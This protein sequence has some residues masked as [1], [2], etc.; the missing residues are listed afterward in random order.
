MIFFKGSFKKR[1]RILASLLA[2]CLSISMVPTAS[3]AQGSDIQGHWAQKTMEKWVSQKLMGGYGEGY[4]KPDQEITRIEFMA[5]LNKSLGLTVGT[6]VSFSD[7]NQGTWKT[8]TAGIA[9]SA[10]YVSGY[11]DGTLK[12]DAP[13]TR[14]EAASMIAKATG[15]SQ[16]DN[17]AAVSIKDMD[18]LSAWS[19]DYVVA[20]FQTKIMGGYGNGHFKPAAKITRAESVAALD[21]VLS[22]YVALD[23]PGVYTAI[24]GNQLVKKHLI[25]KT[26]GVT[27]KGLE[28]QGQIIALGNQNTLTLNG[29]FGDIFVVG[30]GAS[31]AIKDK[32]HL[33]KLTIS[34]A[35]TGVNVD[36]DEA[37]VI[38]KV[39]MRG[40]TDLRGT[41]TVREA[42]AFANGIT[43]QKAPLK[44]T[45]DAKVALKPTATILVVDNKLPLGPVLPM[46]AV[47]P[48]GATLPP[49]GGGS[50]G[51][52]T[53]PP[54]GGGSSGGGG[55]P[56]TPTVPVPIKT[57][58]PV[59]NCSEV[60]IADGTDTFKVAVGIKE[61]YSN[62]TTTFH[63]P[64]GM[65]AKNSD[66][67]RIGSGAAYRTIGASPQVTLNNSGNTVTVKNIETSGGL[68]HYLELVLQDVETQGV[69]A[70]TMSV[71][72]DK[73]GDQ[74]TFT[75]SEPLD[76]RFAFV[77][78]Q[79]VTFK[80]TLPT[81]LKPLSEFK[82][83]M[84]LSSSTPSGYHHRTITT[85]IKNCGPEDAFSIALPENSVINAYYRISEDS[86]LKLLTDNT[87]VIRID[88]AT[89][90]SK[91]QEIQLESGQY[92]EGTLILPSDLDRNL[93]HGIYMIAS[94][95]QNREIRYYLNKDFLRNEI[96]FKFIARKGQNRLRYELIMK[97]SAD[98]A[99]QQWFTT[100]YYGLTG[101]TPLSNG[102]LIDINNDDISNLKFNV[103]KKSDVNVLKGQLTCFSE[104][105]S[106]LSRDIRLAFASDY[107]AVNS[108]IQF[109]LPEGIK[110]ANT[111]LISLG[112][113]SLR[114]T[115]AELGEN[116]SISNNG[117]TLQFK[118]YSARTNANVYLTLKDRI[119]PEG[120]YQFNATVDLDGPGS[121]Y[122][123]SHPILSNS[124]VSS[125]HI[126]IAGTIKTIDGKPNMYE[127]KFFLITYEWTESA[128]KNNRKVIDITDLTIPIGVKEV[129]FKI[130]LPR[131]KYGIALS[132]INTGVEYLLSANGELVK[133]HNQAIPFDLVKNNIENVST[134]LLPNLFVQVT[135]Q[136]LL[137][138]LY[139][140]STNSAQSETILNYENTKEFT[141]GTLVFEL[142]EAIAFQTG[143]TISTVSGSNTQSIFDSNA[144][145]DYDAVTH[146]LTIKNLD[147]GAGSTLR[148]KM[149]RL[150]KLL[151]GAY[152]IKVQG[153]NDGE[154]DCFSPSQWLSTTIE[155]N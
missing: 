46:P 67:I 65:S 120:T 26:D 108:E 80:P 63:L 34:E 61:T 18:Q 123:M 2:L 110:F 42:E 129:T 88:N 27:L 57:Q 143:D 113:G 140:K 4:Y 134:V 152:T 20:V 56:T 89:S 23:K 45:L 124:V 76:L 5:L 103:I 48:G 38:E 10:G 119:V 22:N 82:L 98:P 99:A 85:T 41:G 148:L 12:P 31:I 83:Y 117:K 78:G 40:A 32:T 145:C 30:S 16:L 52:S 105:S 122:V 107:E 106:T 71:T 73:D 92:I 114:R 60:L 19:Q 111:D 36:L 66:Q 101:T 25:I 11:T 142:P 14:E 136:G 90:P 153:D 87:I 72:V 121:V 100:G 139:S 138:H 55:V 128:T 28:V 127:K 144:S 131:G 33:T 118:N 155:I 102:S 64:Q 81:D 50:P 15:I 109:N 141:K 151:K 59:A 51:G 75:E 147:M 79:L 133:H 68:N 77:K 47:T 74:L 13:I 84:N 62:G 8:K 49:A 154:G 9:M 44:W 126:G 43:Y 93:L 116:A 3:F 35:S 94:N 135:A 17:K 7:M 54:A 96:P 37:V 97:N 6:D 132:Q 150:F 130:P 149:S 91:V 137:Q 86:G 95:G 104:L 112:S 24:E 115:I 70:A 29:T 53:P 146:L 69:G 125:P 1:R 39:T 58:K 21:G